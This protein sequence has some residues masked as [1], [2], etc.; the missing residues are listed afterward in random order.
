MSFRRFDAQRSIYTQ[1]A[2]AHSDFRDGA[3]LAITGNVHIDDGA[4]ISA[5]VYIGPGVS[6]GSNSVVGAKSV[7][8]KNVPK[9]E[10]WGGVP[11]RLIRRK[12]PSAPEQPEVH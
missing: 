4:W 11:A 1:T 10:I 6:I 9:T 8:T 12:R 7:V 5:N 3:G 2:E